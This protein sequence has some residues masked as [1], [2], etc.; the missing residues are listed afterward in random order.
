MWRRYE[1]QL[2]DIPGKT[3]KKSLNTCQDNWSS[4]QGLNLG[5]LCT[6]QK[7]LR[8]QYDTWY[9]HHMGVKINLQHFNTQIFSPNMLL[10]SPSFCQKAAPH[11]MSHMS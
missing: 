11:L 7:Y 5:L 4:G 3:N 2:Q 6:K 9:S 1:V 8:L 10:V